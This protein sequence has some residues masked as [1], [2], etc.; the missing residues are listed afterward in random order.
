[1]TD[2]SVVKV[3]DVPFCNVCFSFYTKNYNVT[4]AELMYHSGTRNV[5]ADAVTLIRVPFNIQVYALTLSSDPDGDAAHTLTFRV[6]E[7]VGYVSNTGS[8]PITWDGVPTSYITPAHTSLTGTAEAGWAT[9]NNVDSNVSYNY[10]WA[11]TNRPTIHNG[12][13]IGLFVKG[14]TNTDVEIM[15]KLWCYQI[16]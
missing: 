14:T 2:H 5:T 1:M 11:A 15:V 9:I 10:T 6:A 3:G 12:R 13:A 7:A 16:P 4:F 8:F